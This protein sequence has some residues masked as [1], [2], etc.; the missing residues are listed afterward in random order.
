MKLRLN[1]A[2]KM[3]A[4]CVAM[5]LAGSAA[6]Q[7]ADQWTAKVGFNKIT[8]K[9]DSG[10]ITAPSLPHSKADVNSD[11][12]PVLIVGYGLTDNISL[13][14]DLGMPYKHKL[15]GADAIAGMGTIATVEALPPTAFIQYHLF[16]PAAMVRPYVG[17]G[18]TYAYF[19]KARG[20]NGF[21]AITNPGA[22]PTTF[23]LENK[24]AGTLQAGVAVAINAKWYADVAVTKTYLKTHAAFSSGQS[25]DIKLDPFAVSL[26]I[27]YKF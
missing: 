12:K 2:V 16:E 6:A 22:T 21:T 3:L 14:L 11:T 27:G 20:S 7:S 15:S 17:L 8:P 23:K 19:Q 24:F 26:G 18:L 5:T 10:D 4:L 1:S 9:V 25:L 13:E